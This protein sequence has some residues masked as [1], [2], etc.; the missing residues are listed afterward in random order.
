S[1]DTDNDGEIDVGETWLYT[2]TFNATQVEMDR[3]ADIVNTATLMT[4]ELPDASSVVTTSINSDPSFT[5]AKT[6]SST[7]AA[8][9]DTVD[10]TF[11]LVNTGNVAINNTAIA[12]AKCAAAP[13]LINE[14]ATS[15]GVLDVGE[16]QTFTCTS[17]PVTQAEVDAETVDNTATATGNP[18]SGILAS[19]QDQL[20]I[21]V[22]PAPSIS[23]NKSTSSSPSQA[24][25]VLTY[26]FLLENTGNITVSNPSIAD[27]KCAASPTL[28]SESVAA[29]GVLDVG[30]VQSYSCVSIPVTQ[31]EVDAGSV[32]NTATAS[33]DPAAGSLTPAVDTL[34]TPISPAPSFSL[35]KSTSS[36][37]TAANDT[38]IYS[39]SLENTGNVSILSPAI[40]DPKCAAAPTLQSE[41]LTSDGVL[42]VGE[43]Q[44]YTCTSIAVTQDEVDAGMVDNTATASGAPAGGSLAPVQ[45]QLSTPI[46]A[47]P[48]IN[49]VKS[50]TSA[51]T[52]AGDTL[53]Y[54][55]TVTNPG[56][57]SISNPTLTD[58]KCASAIIRTSGDTD[59]DNSLD[60]GETHIFECMSVA[61]TQAEADAGEV[62]NTVTASGTPVGGT[63]TPDSDTE[64]V[65]IASA[66]ALTLDKRL[67][68]AS[69]TTYDT[70]GDVL[71]YEFEV[72]NS[73]NVTLGTAITIADAALDAQASCPT[74][75]SG[76]LLPGDSIVC[77]GQRTIDQDDLDAGS[78]TNTA[79]A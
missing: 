62:E 22:T 9:G 49:V 70:V 68:A 34:S 4:N 56:N 37:P 61:V 58:A 35:E 16:T 8:A 11:T 20:S 10:Y 53:V 45:D 42:E 57:V 19:V 44:I 7:P 66:P 32:D 29:N 28:Q 77:T 67:A 76:R 60:V 47:A 46:A 13:T 72:T 21:A 75:P 69:P 23:L 73:G 12:D 5:L 40:A 15:D 48:A 52:Q 54:T 55:F 25:D 36:T 38:L 79:S 64:T 30:E 65:P 1:G 59:G 43:T 3:G 74:L 27:A 71:L 26:T 14:T 2:V 78:V 33:G 24:G 39:F 41:D 17:I 31:T 6:S 18:T 50:T 63:L 51:P